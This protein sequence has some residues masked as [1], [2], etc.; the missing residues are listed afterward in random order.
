MAFNEGHPNFNVNAVIENA[1]GGSGRDLIQGNKADN[2]LQGRAGL[3]SLNG[4]SGNDTLD[5]A[6][7]LIR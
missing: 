4:G 6:S 5:G 1:V 7:A 3:D 2:V